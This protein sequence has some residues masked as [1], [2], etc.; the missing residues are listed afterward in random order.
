M[1]AKKAQAPQDQPMKITLAPAVSGEMKPRYRLNW[2]QT[3]K[4]AFYVDATVELFGTDSVNEHP[5]HDEGDVK[6]LSIGQKMAAMILEGE[7][8][9]LRQGR[10]L[11]HQTHVHAAAA[12]QGA[13]ANKAAGLTS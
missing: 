12:A 2:K 5:A 8:D 4:G 3:S 6:V 7:L 11:A 10:V 13:A 9:L 1:S